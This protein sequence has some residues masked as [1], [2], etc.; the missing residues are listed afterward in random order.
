M[1][2]SKEQL[3]E[4]YVNQKLS[5]VE[6]A[7]LCKRTPKTI[8]KL[9]QKKGIKKRTFSEQ[10]KL[11]R[12]SFKYISEENLKELYWGSKLSTYQISEK[13]GCSPSGIFYKM[14]KF[15][16]PLRTLSEGVEL[17]VAR[18]SKSISR[19]INKY[20]KKDFDGS[21]TEKAYLV[22]FRIGDLHVF[23][24]KYG[25]TIYV[26]S[27]TSKQEQLDLMDSL[28]E[29]YGKISKYD[30]KSGCTQFSC[31]LN[32]SFDF[33]LQKK[34]EI[35]EWV[36]SD[37]KN[38]VSFLA[39][40]VD[41][42]GHF[43]V[44]NNFAEFSVSSYDSN[45]LFT[46]HKKLDKLGIYTAEPKIVTEE[47]HVDKRGVRW[48]GTLYRLRITRKNDLLKFILLIKSVVKH[49]KRLEDLKM[50][51]NSILERNKRV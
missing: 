37:E 9:M 27:G 6:V 50:A 16:I 34:D 36:V 10:A 14:K 18:R 48:N 32:R 25:E 45:I 46:I 1:G 17:S 40:Y 22:G 19:S 4:L 33:L 2:I 43:G 49:A 7:K 47:G 41:A 24:K 51:E 12:K 38:F 21:D 42:E 3:K 29:K 8:S 20:V 11:S 44:Y 30:L 13:V 23:K 31:N 35:S 28:F 26:S 5:I 39:G 15:N